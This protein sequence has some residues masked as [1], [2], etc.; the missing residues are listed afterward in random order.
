MKTM[1]VKLHSLDY[2][3]AKTYLA[4][5]L[6]IAGNMALPQL[7]HLLP[8]G[9]RILLPIYFFTLLGAYKFGWKVG[10]LTAILSPVLN[11][12]LFGM[13]A[14]AAL[15]TILVKSVLLAAIAGYAAHRTRRVTLAILAGVVLGAQAVGSL[16][17]W[18][19]T[20][21][22]LEAAQDFRLG[23]PGMLLQIVGV[24]AAIKY[25]IRG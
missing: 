20:G 6:F 12:A 7:C 15:P 14:A 8:D 10:L 13:P 24:W 5:T 4:A 17:E 22:L 1:T 21:S 23:A 9:G 11:A 25:A 16:F 18:A 19:Y 3:Q 2:G